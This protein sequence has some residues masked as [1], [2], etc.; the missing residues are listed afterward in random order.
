MTTSPFRA[1]LLAGKVALVTGG[2]SGIGKGIAATLLQHGATVGIV[3]RNAERLAATAEALSPH[4]T[5]IALPTDVRDVDGVTRI[6]DQLVTDH[7]GLH[8]LVNGAA[9]NFL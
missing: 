4:G 8:V 9:G 5:C 7:G 2:G 6:V 1:D 3:G